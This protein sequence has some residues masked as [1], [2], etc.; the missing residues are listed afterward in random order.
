MTS[1]H[2][3]FPRS[4]GLAGLRLPAMP[5]PT[6]ALRTAVAVASDLGVHRCHTYRRAFY[7][8]VEVRLG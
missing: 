5:G 7:Q 8:G 3:Q 4:T 2:P 6:S 1:A